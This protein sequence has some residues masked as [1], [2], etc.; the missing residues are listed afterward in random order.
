MC[1]CRH[2]CPQIL[3]DQ[4]ETSLSS[5]FDPL[6]RLRSVVLLSALTQPLHFHSNYFGALFSCDR[7][8]SFY[9][10]AN[11]FLFFRRWT[12]AHSSASS[13]VVLVLWSA[14]DG[15]AEGEAFERTDCRQR[16]LCR[17]QDWFWCHDRRK[18]ARRYSSLFLFLDKI[19]RSSDV[20]CFQSVKVYTNSRD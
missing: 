19:E 16:E 20:I 11:W 7:L 6:P 4:E 13:I 1:M 15:R 8:F 9:H 12:C 17:T 10:S 18:E 3:S 14:D 2:V 5:S